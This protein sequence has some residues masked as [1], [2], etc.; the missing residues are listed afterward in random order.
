[1]PDAFTDLKRITKSHIP[2]ENVSIRIDV[3]AGPSISMR[4]S[5]PKA[6]LNRSRPMGSKDRNPRKKN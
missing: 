2:A 4:A 1:M 3:P 6:R 5:E